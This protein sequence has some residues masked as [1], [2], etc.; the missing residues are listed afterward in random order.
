MN[1]DQQKQMTSK[2]L[3][4][5]AENPQGFWDGT[6]NHDVSQN[7]NALL[8]HIQKKGPLKILDFGCGP[9]RDLKTFGDCG[10]D[11]YGLDGC[12]EFCHMAEKHSGRK[13]FHQD[14]IDLDLPQQFF[15]GIFA[16]AS[17]FHVPK[18]NLPHLLQALYRT[19]TSDGILFSSNPRGDREDLHGARYANFMELEEYRMIVER[20]GFE[21]LNHYYRPQGQP[22]EHCPWLACIFQKK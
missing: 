21:Y 19:L 15:D 3:E 6:K 2:T 7:I 16:N 17:L 20:E 22:Q 12:E 11:A 1:K 9:G 13:V 18:T 14:F 4:Y 5:Y 10:H 8:G